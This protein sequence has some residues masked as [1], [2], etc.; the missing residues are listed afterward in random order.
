MKTFDSDVILAVSGI[1]EDYVKALDA[2]VV[3]QGVAFGN[4]QEADPCLPPQDPAS[5]LGATGRVTVIRA[6]LADTNFQRQ[7]VEIKCGGD[8]SR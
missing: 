7:K 2:K 1:L 8:D 3:D 5:V 4:L 6:P